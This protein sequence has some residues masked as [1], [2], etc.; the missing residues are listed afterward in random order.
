LV[1]NYIYANDAAVNELYFEFKNIIKLE[2]SDD[3]LLLDFLKAG[4]CVP[5][6]ATDLIYS[7]IPTQKKRTVWS[8]PIIVTGSNTT[9][10]FTIN[11]PASSDLQIGSYLVRLEFNRN[12]DTTSFW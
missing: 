3:N 8:W 4:F 2:T 6:A 10:D 1:H 5:T 12:Q 11:K 7:F 9:N